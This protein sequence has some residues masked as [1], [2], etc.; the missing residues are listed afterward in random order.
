MNDIKFD[1]TCQDIFIKKKIYSFQQKEVGE[2]Y[3]I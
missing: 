2:Q 1:I 3:A